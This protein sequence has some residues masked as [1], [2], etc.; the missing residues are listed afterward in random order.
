MGGSGCVSCH[1]TEDWKKAAFDHSRTSFP[2]L[3]KH[4]AAACSDCHKKQNRGNG[5]IQLA[6]ASSACESCHKEIH[7][8][9]FASDGKTECSKCHKPDNWTAVTFDHETQSSFPLQGAHKT[10][11]CKDCHHAESTGQSRF[12]RFKPLA[13][14]CAS[15]HG[16]KEVK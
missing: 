4:A 12:V 7:H 14:A 5:A 6:K 13:S 11:A 1:A 10:V 3:G 15:C 9:Q 8:G 2:L 16:Q